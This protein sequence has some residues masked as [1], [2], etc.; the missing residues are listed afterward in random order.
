MAVGP[1]Y[2]KYGTWVR[3][4]ELTEVRPGQTVKV[5]IVISQVG[6]SRADLAR[7]RPTYCFLD[8]PRQP[9][10]LFLCLCAPTYLWQGPP[11][12]PVASVPAVA[13]PISHLGWAPEGVPGNSFPLREPRDGLG[14]RGRRREGQWLCEKRSRIA[15][16]DGRSI[17]CTRGTH[18]CSRST[19]CTLRR[20]VS[21]DSKRVCSVAEQ[22]TASS[23]LV[24]HPN[25]GSCAGDKSDS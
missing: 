2:L 12:F 17:R 4:L 14:H 7:P 18:A 24:V 20:S 9:G 25:I 10:R 3:L 8:Y 13:F 22:S 21:F 15:I 11:S 6:T 1:K 23:Y 5:N 16:A 19:S